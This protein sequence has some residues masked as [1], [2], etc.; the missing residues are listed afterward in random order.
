MDKWIKLE[1]SKL[2]LTLSKSK[3]K[4]SISLLGD[5]I[6]PDSKSTNIIYKRSKKYNYRDGQMTKNEEFKIILK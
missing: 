1:N 2:N 5:A 3:I 4:K 6:L